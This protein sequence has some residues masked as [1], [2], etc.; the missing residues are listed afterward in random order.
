MAAPAS[1]GTCPVCH[2]WKPVG[3]NGRLWSHARASTNPGGRAITNRMSCPGAGNPPVEAA[4][5]AAGPS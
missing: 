1:H 2:A 3:A 4:Q 5:K